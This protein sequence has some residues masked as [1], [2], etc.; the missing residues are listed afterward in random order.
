M[1]E[2]FVHKTTQTGV[3]MQKICPDVYTVEKREKN[4][5]LRRPPQLHR[6]RQTH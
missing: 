6:C 4:N 1:F 2:P 5:N 3:E